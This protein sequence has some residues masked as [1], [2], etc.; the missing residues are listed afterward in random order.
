[1]MKRTTVVLL[2]SLVFCVGSVI[3]TATE[4][5]ACI[6]CIA[7]HCIDDA[8]MHTICTEI[9]GHGCA[10]SGNCPTGRRAAFRSS[11]L[12]ESLERKSFGRVPLT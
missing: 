5:L 7:R 2:V 8:G 12:R 9:S 4:A 3:I 1:M 6:D 11:Y 10:A